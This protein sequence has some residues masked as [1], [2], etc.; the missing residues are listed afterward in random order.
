[1]KTAMQTVDSGLGKN[2]VN[3][4]NRIF[5]RLDGLTPTTREQRRLTALERWGLLDAEA[6]S[7]FDE[8]T[9]M[10]AR[11]LETP[12][13][14]LGLL[15]KD[16]LWLK[17]SVGLSSIGLMNQLATSRTIPR[18]EAF[19]TYVVDSEQPLIIEDSAIDPVFSHS[20]LFQH[21][22]IRSYLGV[23]LV[24]SDG[25]CLGALAVM[26]LEPRQFSARDIDYLLLTARW[27]SSEFERNRFLSE[28]RDSSIPGST[29]LIERLSE[30]PLISQYQRALK[31]GSLPG[32]PSMPATNL[33][34]V[35]ATD[36]LKVRLLTQLTEELR[37][38]LTSVMG[39]ARILGQEVYGALTL[40][41][42]EYVEI[43]HDSGQH[44]L[45][46]VEE[47]VNLGV[48]S[49]EDANLQLTPV[50]IEMLCQQALNNLYQIAKQERQRLRLS[51]EP[52]PRLWLLDKEKVRQALYYLVYTVIQSAESGSE[53]RIHISRKESNLNLSVW[54]SHPWLGDG[55]P[56][57]EMYSQPLNLDISPSWD[58]S[59][60]ASESAMLESSLSQ[61]ILTD[62]SL[63]PLEKVEQL[64]EKSAEESY[65]EILGLVLSCHLAELHGGSIV[66]QG[67]LQSG[68]R[69]IFRLP[70]IETH[71]N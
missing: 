66:I 2:M 22:G 30:L 18:N 12:I 62:S 19:C 41:Q 46:L 6:V 13:A 11:A 55:L 42:K 50:D 21:Y 69:Y 5:C 27:C 60:Q 67:S 20:I 33:E 61:Q 23:P 51:V 38:P 4:H 16:K 9:Q 7:V 40:K 49:A 45:A 8:A 53:I 57:V 47:I 29:S 58:I 54:V 63:S 1:M 3:P 36:A 34:T 25:Q 52:G 56:Q 28:R 31:T 26:D 14:I 17:S 64:K 44:L 68:Y 15:I 48:F 39:M 71:E 43:I 59:N 32:E 24:L 65:R 37:T 70:K 35:N 10:S